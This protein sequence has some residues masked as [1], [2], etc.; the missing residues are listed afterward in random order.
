MELVFA[1]QDD[2]RR[3]RASR[4]GH[5]LRETLF[6]DTFADD[7]SDVLRSQVA[8]PSFDNRLYELWLTPD[9][10][11]FREGPVNVAMA[12]DWS[13]VRL[14]A[15][16]GAEGLAIP[17]YEAYRQLFACVDQ[18]RLGHLVRIWNYIPHLLGHT[19]GL[20]R[21]RQFNIGRS[22]AWTDF[23][24]N[25]PNGEPWSPAATGIGSYDGPLIVEALVTTRPVVYL[26][27]P[28]QA[29]AHRYSTKYGPKPPVFS[30]GTLC[31]GPRPE[32]YLA[33]TASLLG[34]DVAWVGDPERQVQETLANMAAVIDD[35]NVSPHG[36]RPGFTLGD[37]RHLRVYVKRRA[38]YERVRA[39][40]EAA[41][42][43]DAPVIYLNDDI[44]RPEFLV[45]I[46]GICSR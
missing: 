23:G 15:E 41:L 39:A 40:V 46:E 1:S 18:Y 19:H 14:V 6:A 34:E 35:E 13:L 30:R 3:L 42:G 25:D 45:E 8:I 21:Y 9:P 7:E 28:R 44:C 38:D 4:R 10:V 12:G 27:N 20:E 2:V 37:L 33:G 32:I 16:E 26:Q 17:A 24:A 5:I 11:T 36:I 31:L 22:L 43:L 29:A